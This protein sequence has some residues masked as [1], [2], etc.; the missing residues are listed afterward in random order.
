MSN[1]SESSSDMNAVQGRV[2]APLLDHNQSNTQQSVLSK[3][4]RG[5]KR[6]RA[7]PVKERLSRGVNL[8]SGTL[9]ARHGLRGCDAV[10]GAARVT[11]RVI[12]R[13]AGSIQVGRA[14]AVIGSYVPVE[15]TTSPSGRLEIGDQVWINFGCLFSARRGIRIGDGCRFGQ[16]CIIA[17]SDSPDDDEAVEI[18]AKPIEIGD[19]VWLAGRVT[20]RPGVTIG[21]G[22]VIAAGSI[23]ET[24]IPP[25]VMAGGV[26]ARVMRSLTNASGAQLIDAAEFSVVRAVSQTPQVSGTLIADFTIDDLVVAL[27]EP[28]TQPPATAMVAPYNQVAQTLLGSPQHGFTDFAVVWVRPAT[29]A[30]SFSR[31][32]VQEQVPERTLLDEVDAFCGLIQRAARQYGLI[33]VPSFC[34]SAWLRGRGMIDFREGGVARALLSLNVRLAENLGRVSNAFMLNADRW[35]RIVGYREE[36]AKGWYLGKMAVP[37]EVITE[38]AADLR[39]AMVGASGLSRK[40]LIVDLDDTLWGG[41]V[42][43]V[44][45]EGLNL[46][47]HDGEG[48]AHVDFQRA[49][50]ALTRRGVILAIASKNEEG[51]A[52]QAISRHPEMVLRQED[53]VAWRINW[54]DKARSIVE[55]ATELKL[56]LQSVAF[57]DDSPVERAR[58]REA[59]PEVFVPEWPTEKYLYTAALEGMR[60]FD[61]PGISH[62]DVQRTRLYQEEREREQLHQQLGSIDDWLRSLD[63]R[64]KAEPLHA[65]NV[66]RAAQL[67]NKTNQLNLSTRRLTE[68]ELMKWA[69]DP[70]RRFWTLNVSDRFGDSGLTGLLSLEFEPSGEA[71]VVDYVLSCRVMGRRIEHT[72]VHMAVAAARGRA[73]RV[74]AKL[75]PTAKNTPCLN[76]WRESGFAVGDT[77]DFSWDP[78][79]DYALPSTVALD[80]QY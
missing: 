20:V 11:G 51:I 38:A 64:V 53:F 68:A 56:G 21:S 72:M 70:S 44:G 46:G 63:I 8:I 75:L 2:N 6:D 18:D 23:V 4:A 12:V 13:N 10:G 45:W 15:L 25:G 60:C 1:D 30:P 9:R 66:T 67:L 54:N 35:F 27:E 36:T 80:W 33:F 41:V 31:V 50:K 19:R 14:L 79:R 77:H 28:G 65:R 47:G 76:F 62:E 49:L 61:V 24:D 26:P 39:A 22:S 59:L 40:L 57:I 37:R 73:S 5:W 69:A 7:L 48:E 42:G 3:I 55:L 43:D 52:L 29:A 71:R 78:S 17:D 74:I 58:V 34:E 32:L 16:Y